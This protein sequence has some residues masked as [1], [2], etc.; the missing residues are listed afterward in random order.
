MSCAPAAAIASRLRDLT[1]VVYD[2]LDAGLKE[3]LFASHR[4]PRAKDKPVIRAGK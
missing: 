4:Q 3:Q 2:G 1:G